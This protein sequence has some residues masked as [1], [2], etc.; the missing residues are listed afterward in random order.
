[1]ESFRQK[2]Y[3]VSVSEDKGQ[4]KDLEYVEK[5]PPEIDKNVGSCGEAAGTDFFESSRPLPASLFSNDQS[6]ISKF[7]TSKTNVT[8]SHNATTT[9]N[10]NSHNMTTTTSRPMTNCH[11][12]T[13]HHIITNHHRYKA[14]VQNHNLFSVVLVAVLLLSNL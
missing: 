5:P 1:M 8:G 13:T 6:S 9:T 14:P 3:E 4:L 7:R 2:C 11:N 12:V 10:S